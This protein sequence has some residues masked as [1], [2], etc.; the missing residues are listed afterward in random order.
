MLRDIALELFARWQRF[1]EN[2]LGLQGLERGALRIAG[3]TTTEYFIA[4]WLA[5]YSASHSGID[6]ELAVDN[7]D[8]VV[9]RLIN[10]EI[11]I[12]VMM[13]PPAQLSL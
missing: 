2:L 6:I 5:D 1:E 11:E 4:E 3:V 7:R 10:D 8:A 9:N 13:M 12:A